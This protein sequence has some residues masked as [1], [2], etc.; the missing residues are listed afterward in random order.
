ML[1]RSRPSQGK[2]LAQ[3]LPE[4]SPDQIK[5]LDFTYQATVGGYVSLARGE[6]ADVR[7]LAPLWGLP[8]EMVLR[9]S[10]EGRELEAQLVRSQFTVADGNRD[11]TIPSWVD[12]TFNQPV[13][14]HKD[15]DGRRRY[16]K[17]FLMKDSPVFYV[18]VSGD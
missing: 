12:I 16:R 11:K 7:S 15:A 8:E 1:N 3:Y 10:P 14:I 18:I 5:R 17:F 2:Y 13:Y 6:L 9:F 4:I